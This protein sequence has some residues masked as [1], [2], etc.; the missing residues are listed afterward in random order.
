MLMRYQ[1]LIK[2]YLINKLILISLLFAANASALPIGMSF[3]KMQIIKD[4]AHLK[5]YHAS[6]SYF[7][8]SLI[9]QKNMV[10]FDA[11]FSRWWLTYSTKNRSLNIYSLSPVFRH[12][13]QQRS[14]ISPFIQLGI[15]L[16]WLTQTRLDKHNLG[17]HFT[18][19]DRIG[20]GIS[21]GPKRRFSLIAEM[22]HYSNASLSANNGG[23][24]APLV[25]TAEYK[26]D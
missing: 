20:A 22:M 15:G 8:K 4:P 9:W 26:F 3:S 24:T 7:P 17:M 14:W 13:F 5:G 16:S 2:K 21:F 18:F 6:I 25:F 10:F 12:Y 1:Y 11:S 19:Q 23:I